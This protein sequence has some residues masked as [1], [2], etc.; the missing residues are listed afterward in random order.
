[1]YTTINYNYK[2]LSPGSK[3]RNLYAN[4]LN[5]MVAQAKTS[6]AFMV[7]ERDY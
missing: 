4:K 3:D 1:M 6:K 2:L 5:T 7:C